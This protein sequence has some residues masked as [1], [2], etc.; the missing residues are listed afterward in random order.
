MI[1]VWLLH[2]PLISVQ[3]QSLKRADPQ[4]KEMYNG[5]TVSQLANKVDYS[6]TDEEQLAMYQGHVYWHL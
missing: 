5:L 2:A 4:S 6:V 3:V 1:G